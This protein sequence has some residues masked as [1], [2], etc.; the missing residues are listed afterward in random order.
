MFE[1]TVAILKDSI[2]GILTGVNITNEVTSLN[3]ALERG[4]RV[5]ATKIA[6]PEAS[7][8]YPI[9]IYSGVN[10][11]EAP[12]SIFGGALTDF[13]KQGNNVSRMNVVFKLPIMPFARTQGITPGG[14]AL[15]FEYNNGVA[16]MGV[17]TDDTLPRINLD[18]MTAD[19]DWSAGG[20]ASGLAED[21]VTYYNSP[22]SLRFNLAAAGSNGYL[23]K[24]LSSALD[25]TDYEGVGVVFLAVYLPNATP[26]TS[27]GCRIGSSASDYFDISATTGFVTDFLS[28]EWQL[29]ALDLSTA[30]ETGTVDIEN[31]D[32]LR[33]YVNY[34]GTACPNVR[35]GDFW[36]ALPSAHNVYFQT[37]AVFKVTG[38][39]GPT[40]TITADSDTILLNSAAYTIY[41]FEA[42][43]AVLLQSGGSVSSPMYMMIKQ[44]LHGG[45]GDIGLY[46]HYSANNPSQ[47]LR[48]YDN[49]YLD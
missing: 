12:P 37:A 32:Y 1:N 3:Q 21:T 28:D 31:I 26:I 41:E 27:I 33:P 40:A 10:W 36:V 7:V 43:A 44:S 29:I 19:T 38:A 15:T 20:N 45:N 11:Y 35:F 8:I 30:T 9:N 39:T 42:A 4:L 23:V 18:P 24:T 49:Y 16:M 13:R 17:K 48:S 6:I 14:T 34:D 25:L 46:N 5:M 47:E 2:R 22:A